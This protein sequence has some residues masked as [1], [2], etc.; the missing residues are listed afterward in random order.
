MVNEALSQ[1]KLL[2]RSVNSSP[3]SYT[4]LPNPSSHCGSSAHITVTLSS[5]FNI[6]WQSINGSPSTSS[7]KSVNINSKSSPSISCPVILKV[8]VSSSNIDI[9]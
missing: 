6:L 8:N 7:G 2:L 5:G 4:P 1:I 3:K 9:F